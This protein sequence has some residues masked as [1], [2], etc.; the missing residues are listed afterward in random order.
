MELDPI[1]KAR[2]EKRYLSRHVCAFCEQPLDQNHCGAIWDKCS[3]EVREKRRLDCLA[4][5]K[6]RGKAK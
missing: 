4:Q 1:I 6:P 5:Y 3:P 2:R